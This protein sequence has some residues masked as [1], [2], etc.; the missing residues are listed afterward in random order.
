M[1]V[2]RMNEGLGCQ[3]QQRVIIVEVGAKLRA[4]HPRTCPQELEV[5]GRDEQKTCMAK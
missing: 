1:E 2:D 3:R 5:A 4:L